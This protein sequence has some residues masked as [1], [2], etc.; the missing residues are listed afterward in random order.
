M[1]TMVDYYKIHVTELKKEKIAIVK[2][3]WNIS[4]NDKITASSSII[5]H[6]F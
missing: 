3:N 4:E 6:M 2:Y 5:L 1:Q